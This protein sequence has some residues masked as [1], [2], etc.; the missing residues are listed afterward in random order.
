M[1]TLT[2]NNNTLTT[3]NQSNQI[4]LTSADVAK[5]LGYK[6]TKSVSN[7]YSNNSDEFTDQMTLVNNK[8]MTMTKFI[9]LML[10]LIVLMLIYKSPEIIDVYAKHFK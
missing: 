8:D 1:N 4:W 2:F 6:S 5:A 3:I 10:T 9:V 7:L